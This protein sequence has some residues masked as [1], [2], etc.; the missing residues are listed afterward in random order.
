M[1]IDIVVKAIMDDDIDK[2][3][4][5]KKEKMYLKLSIILNTNHTARF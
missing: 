3:E 5:L 1:P 2:L 4:S